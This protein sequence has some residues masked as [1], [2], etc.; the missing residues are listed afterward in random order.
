[1]AFLELIPLIFQLSNLPVSRENYF[2]AKASPAKTPK[3]LTLTQHK[4]NDW[5]K[6]LYQIG[7]KRGTKNTIYTKSRNELR[8]SRV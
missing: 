4:K 3:A 1:M 5:I 8:S 2:V 6:K 7:S